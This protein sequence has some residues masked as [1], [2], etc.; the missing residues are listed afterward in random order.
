M[1]D[2]R[3]TDEDGLAADDVICIP[4]SELQNGDEILGMKIENMVWML[5]VKRRAKGGGGGDG[6]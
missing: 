6:E 4:A 2:D 5:V 1:D 3:Q